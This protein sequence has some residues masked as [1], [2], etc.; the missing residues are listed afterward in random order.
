MASAVS[1]PGIDPRVWLTLA[2]VKDVGYDSDEG[3][4]ADVQYQ[5]SGDFETAL[6]GAAYAGSRFGSWRPVRVDDTVLVAVP[7]GDPGHGPVIVARMWNAGD[8][9][10]TD[11]GSGE[12]PAEDTIDVIEPGK[13]YI[14]KTSDNGVIK[15]QS[16]EQAF[17][18]GDDYADA[19]GAFLDALTVFSNG[20]QSAP[21]TPPNGALTVAAV[22][23]LAQA[24]SEAISQFKQARSNYLSTKIKGE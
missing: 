16:A 10:A 2:V 17:V 3:L 21:P 1:R 12:D 11:F 20:L 14:L 9:P 5:P 6:I 8:K 18:R 7:M 19:L 13:N 15:L 23:P 24:L 4:F 22:I